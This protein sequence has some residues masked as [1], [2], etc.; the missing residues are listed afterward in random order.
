MRKLIVIVTLATALVASVFTATPANA[1]AFG[2]ST[3]GPSVIIRG[4]SLPKGTYCVQISGTGTYVN[5]VYGQA[6]VNNALAGTT[7]NYQMTAE[8]FDSAGRWYE[9]KASP[10]RYSCFSAAGASERINIGRYMKRGFMCSTL[11]SNGAR[12]TSVCHNIY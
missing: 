3:Y 4:V 5:Y 6:Q 1:G 7:C 8:F 9:T 12:L 10:V 2:C 11:K